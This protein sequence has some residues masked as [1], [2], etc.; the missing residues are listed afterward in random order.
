MKYR[1][2]VIK[3]LTKLGVVEF[4]DVLKADNFFDV[5]DSLERGYIEEV[6]DDVGTETPAGSETKSDSEKE[7]TKPA[8]D[9]KNL[10]DKK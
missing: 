10:T 4:G 9:F 8:K 3:M 1:V 7:E 5:N 2:K 6:K